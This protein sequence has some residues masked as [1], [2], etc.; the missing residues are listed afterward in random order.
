[1]STKLYVGNLPYSTV[2]HQLKELFDEYGEVAAASVVVDRI[3]GRA[4]G[5]GFVEYTTPEAAQK[6]M[7]AMNGYSLE[8]RSL[9]VDI[10][11]ERS[12]GGD[13][14]GD[15]AR[16]PPRHGGAGGPKRGG[17]RGGPRSNRPQ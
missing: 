15:G 2:D 17:G 3:T 11:R 10:A 12:G 8:G 6:A 5:F 9:T 4:R 1:M 7:E 13:R 16:R 14:G